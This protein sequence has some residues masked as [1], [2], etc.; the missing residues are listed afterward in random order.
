MQQAPRTG[1]ARPGRGAQRKGSAGRGVERGASTSGDHAAALAHAAR[2]ARPAKGKSQVATLQADKEA[3]QASLAILL[4]LGRGLWGEQ[5]GEGSNQ[6]N[7]VRLSLA[8]ARDLER[9]WLHDKVARAAEAFETGAPNTELLGR[10]VEHA[11]LA[12]RLLRQV[13]HKHREAGLLYALASA[14]LAMARIKVATLLVPSE[15]YDKIMEGEDRDDSTWWG[16]PRSLRVSQ[17]ELDA[18]LADVRCEK[19]GWP[20]P[21]E[22]FKESKVLLDLESKAGD[23]KKRRKGFFRGFE[24]SF[25]S[26]APPR[27]VGPAPG[28]RGRGR[29]PRSRKPAP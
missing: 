21:L 10:S 1:R 24:P 23:A 19:A 14:D 11:L 6:R 27:P 4:A 20:D 9:G 18:L 26:G 12:R 5:V 3:F 17:G 29:K 7:L 15:I 13:A 16:F 28:A 25:D 8:L 2:A 22:F